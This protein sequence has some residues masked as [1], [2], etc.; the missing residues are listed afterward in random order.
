VLPKFNWRAMFKWMT[1]HAE[2]LPPPPPLPK[3]YRP[4]AR[5]G[6][7]EALDHLIPAAAAPRHRSAVESTEPATSADAT[8]TARPPR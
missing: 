6:Y 5:L 7:P 1:P 4:L 3:E 2:R 8:E